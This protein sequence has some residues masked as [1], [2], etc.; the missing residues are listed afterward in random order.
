MILTYREVGRIMA[1]L[2][3]VYRVG[4]SILCQSLVH[5]MV[6]STLTPCLRKSPGKISLFS[7]SITNLASIVTEEGLGAVTC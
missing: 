3:L 2:F 5:N 1:R 4:R 6:E 7:K